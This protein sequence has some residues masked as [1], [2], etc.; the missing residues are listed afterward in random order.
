MRIKEKF[1]LAYRNH[2]IVEERSEATIEK[3]MRDIR[4]FYAYLEKDKRV[5][6]EV[7]LAYKKSLLE[8]YKISSVNS[9]LIAINGFLS[10]LNLMSCK[11]KLCKFQRRVFSD[12][13]TELSK[14][15]YLRLLNVAKQKDNRLYILMQTFGTTGIR[16]SEH[17]AIS[18][19]A[20]R[21]GKAT[22]MNKGKVREI[23]LDKKLR[24][25]L[26]SYCKQ[27][28]ILSG[29]VFVTKKGKPL[30]RSNIWK[31]MK[32]LCVDAKVEA[33]KV[34]PHNLRHLFA[35]TFY[36]IEKNLV[37]LAGLLGH[38]SI[39]TTR[40]YTMSSGMDCIRSISRLGLLG[41]ITG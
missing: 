34:F 35:F 25:I 10:Y 41:V 21:K 36:R 23:Y 31:M 27:N 26:L 6:K 14:E 9:M 22:V 11:V 37:H 13:N 17:R 18:V 12:E 4:A 5:N 3:Y 33:S 40:I 24:K 20:I 30:D 16:V 19:E 29:P 32:K 38:S 8:S 7:V 39:E 2:L 15:E 1:I 28:K